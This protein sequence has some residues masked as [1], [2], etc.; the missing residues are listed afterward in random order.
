MEHIKTNESLTST[1]LNNLISKL[2][3]TIPN[4]PNLNGRT[5][6]YDYEAGCTIISI[7]WEGGYHI[8][9]SH[10]NYI[11]DF[12]KDGDMIGVELLNYVPENYK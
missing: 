11:L 3:K 7:T 1:Q 2:E 12:N 8:S 5:I 9:E 6:S 10:A 4:F